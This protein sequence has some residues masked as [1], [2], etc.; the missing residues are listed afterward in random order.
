LTCFILLLQSC[1]SADKKCIIKGKTIGVTSK[2]ILLLKANEDYLSE[3]IEIPIKDSQFEYEMEIDQPE[4]VNLMLGEARQDGGRKQTFFIEPGKISLT[5]YPEKEFDKNIVI[6]DKLN[7]EYK[8]FRNKE[9]SIFNQVG[10]P[11]SDSL[12]M[13]FNSGNYESESMKILEVEMRK[14]QDHS[15]NNFIITRD[16]INDLRNSGKDL[17]DKARVLENKQIKI[18]QECFERQLDYINGNNSIVSYYLLYDLL[19]RIKGKVDLE[20]ATSCYQK[21]SKKYPDHPYSSLVGNL[22]ESIKS[23]HVGGRYIDFTA[24]DINGNLVRLSKV[25]DGKVTLIDLWSTWCG[26]CIATSRSLIPVYEAFKNNGFTIIG[27]VADKDNL[28]IKERTEKEKHPWMTLVELDKQNKIW[29]KYGISNG[30]GGT[31]LIGKDGK[32]VAINPTADEVKD[33]LRELLK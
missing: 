23:I 20:I 33:K 24:P 12:D 10:K 15:N 26:P 32:I 2:S 11:I 8:N 4:G 21:L 30:G 28:R 29:E 25:I 5:I 7:N 31:Y 6:G 13:L 27:V 3:G 19:D 9:D 16:K 18:D 14:I 17:S 1:S 22:L